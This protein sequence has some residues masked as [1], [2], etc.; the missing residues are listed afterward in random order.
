MTKCSRDH[1]G[2]GTTR[3]IQSAGLR[4]P[5][6]V[7]VMSMS[8]PHPLAYRRP[9]YLSALLHSSTLPY[10][11]LGIPSQTDRTRQHG[12][13]A[14]NSDQGGA[15]ISHASRDLRHGSS[16]AS[17]SCSGSSININQSQAEQRLSHAAQG[18]TSSGSSGKTPRRI[19]R[20]E[21]ISPS[22][23]HCGEGERASC[24]SGDGTC[25]RSGNCGAVVAQGR[26]RGNG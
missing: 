15:K 11:T 4:V 14:I 21:R 18:R 16:R 26:T 6:R 13:D 7:S 23:A 17:P 10:T 19:S 25:T 24:R 3:E 8:A 5:E 1:E 20:G 22:D 2:D 12:N 9:P